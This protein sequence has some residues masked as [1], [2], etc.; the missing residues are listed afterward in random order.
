KNIC[1]Y[2]VRAKNVYLDGAYLNNDSI[3]KQAKNNTEKQAND[4]IDKQANDS[5]EKQA[6][7]STE[8]QANDNIDKQVNDS[9]DKQA[10]NSTELP[11]QYRFNQARLKEVV[12]IRFSIPGLTSYQPTYIVEE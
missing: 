12:N 11:P 1:F 3:V 2:N 4:N 9:T 10:N 5:T 7:E 8:K 6:N